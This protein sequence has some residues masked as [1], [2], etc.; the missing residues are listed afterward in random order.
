MTDASSRR[1][2][3]PTD[4]DTAVRGRQPE[5]PK[6]RQE[7]VQ[8]KIDLA[9]PAYVHPLVD[10]DVWD[11]LAMVARHLRFVIVNVDSGPGA[12]LD[13]AY[14]PVIEQLRASRARLV[15]YV[16]TDYG[17]R[18]V[19]DVV[20]DA[21]SWVLRYGVRG[22]FFDQVAG[23]FEHL[24]YY[25]A[26]ALGARACGAQYV[27][28]NPGADCHPGYAD[29][30]NVTVTFEGTWAEYADHQ[31]PRW[32]L[33]M[34][35]SRF[36]HLVHA[37]P[38]DRIAAGP[39][40]TAG[41]HAGTAFFTAGIGSNPWDQLPAAVVDAVDRAHPRAVTPTAGAQSWAGRTYAQGL[42]DSTREGPPPTT[43]GPQVPPAVPAAPTARTAR[44]RRRKPADL[45]QGAG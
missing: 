7:A 30:A 24:E 6:G 27:V 5:G 39:A 2:S 3:E 20:A 10:P 23:D 19:E 37:V 15:G 35:A 8:I 29:I 41:L 14:P 9:V 44:W 34:P 12:S 1:M 32:T 22:V 17:R 40:R 33:A 4:D 38:A 43:A 11:R 16:D 25:A 28:L 42:K 26:C 13:P 36:C 45:A 31:P 18:S 21:R